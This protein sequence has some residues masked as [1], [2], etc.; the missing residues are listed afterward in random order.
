M[1]TTY[2]QLGNASGMATTCSQMGVLARDRGGSAD[3]SVALH[4][5]ALAIRLRPGVPEAG[6]DLRSLAAPRRFFEQ[7]YPELGTETGQLGTIMPLWRA[8]GWRLAKKRCAVER[9]SAWASARDDVAQ[10]R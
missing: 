8:I 5:R 4:M 2:H 9:L 10:C 6:I 1:A 7:L 3:Q